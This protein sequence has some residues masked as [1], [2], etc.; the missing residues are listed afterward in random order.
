MG[1][2][3]YK[4]FCKAGEDLDEALKSRGAYRSTQMVKC[5]VDYERPAEIWMNNFLLSL[6][7][8]KKSESK[9]EAVSIFE[10]NDGFAEDFSRT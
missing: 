10:S 1:D 5:D 3:T 6:S 7:P 2:K 4:H 9:D 8:S